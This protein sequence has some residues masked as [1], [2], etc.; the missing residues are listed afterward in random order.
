[1]SPISS[2][3]HLETSSSRVWRI[4]SQTASVRHLWSMELTRTSAQSTLRWGDNSE[5]IL[6]MIHWSWVLVSTQCQ[7]CDHSSGTGCRLW[8]LATGCWHWRPALT[9]ASDGDHSSQCSVLSEPTS[10]SWPTMVH[11]TVSP[12][13]VLWRWEIILN[14]FKIILTKS[15]IYCNPE[16]ISNLQSEMMIVLY[17]SSNEQ[18]QI[19]YT[20][21]CTW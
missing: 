17:F 1:M 10:A 8:W 4:M 3:L 6:T 7:S 9:Q 11:H 2:T 12:G 18:N 15:K 21:L 5:W 13:S 16:N 19:H 20:K 14:N